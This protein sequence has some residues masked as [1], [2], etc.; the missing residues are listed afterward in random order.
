[1][2]RLKPY[3]NILYMEENSRC[4]HEFLIDINPIKKKTGVTE[5]DIAKRLIDYCFHAPTMSFPIP[6]TLMI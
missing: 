4:S 5:E 3:Y 2:S 1:M 6:G